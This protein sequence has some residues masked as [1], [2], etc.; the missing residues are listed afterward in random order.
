MS[1]SAESG[2]N[3]EFSGSLQYQENSQRPQSMEV[4]LSVDGDKT[5]YHFDNSKGEYKLENEIAEKIDS[6]S[7]ELLDDVLDETKGYISSYK[8]EF[9]HDN[10]PSRLVV[11]T[12]YKDE[13]GN[14]QRVEQVFDLKNKE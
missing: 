14:Y 1:D 10:E 4:E 12:T 7:K 2:K 5:K 6:G 9:G 11:T 13:Y 8:E 3:V